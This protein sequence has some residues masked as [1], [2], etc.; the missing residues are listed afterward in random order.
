MKQT[1]NQQRL[2]STLARDHW[3]IVYPEDVATA[4]QLARVGSI[5]YRNPDGT[6]EGEAR[7]AKRDGKV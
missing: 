1:I 7:L 4:K 5:E 2:L 3:T 6:P